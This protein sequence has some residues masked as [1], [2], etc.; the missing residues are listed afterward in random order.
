LRRVRLSPEWNSFPVWIDAPE[1]DVPTDIPTEEL[2]EHFGVPADIVAEIDAWDREWQS[3][4][5]PDDPRESGFADE[6]TMHG[7]FERGLR[8]ARRLASEFGPGVTV[9]V[10]KEGGGFLVAGST[11]E[12]SYFG[13][14]P[15]GRTRD[16]LGGVFRRSVVDGQPVD[17]VF[18]RR[19]RWEPTSALRERD[20]GYGDTEYIEITEA[21]A[22]AFVHR[23]RQKPPS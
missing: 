12:V 4:Y 18:T 21:D 14:V 7:W 22:D 23:A 1:Y 9:E 5:R 3:I 16:R 6:Q 11:S 19:L 20:L 2:T 15:P 13:S 10:N 8:V 17:E